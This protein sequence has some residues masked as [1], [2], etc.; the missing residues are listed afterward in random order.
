MKIISRKLLSI[1]L[2]IAM[3]MPTGMLTLTSNAATTLLWPVPGH[4]HN[5]PYQS[6]HQN[7]NGIDIS[8]GS[9]A[10]ANV[11][12]A[13]GGKVVRIY[14]CPNV[15]AP[16]EASYVTC[17]YG[18]GFGLV[19]QG[20]DGRW[21][22][23]AHMLA[24]SIPNNVY[25]GGYVATGTVLGKVGSTGSSTGNHL[26][27][28]IN[29]QGPG[30]NQGPV[31]PM[32]E[33]YVYDLSGLN[34]PYLD[35][36][37]KLDGV[38]KGVLGGI[39]TFD[40]Y[41]NG[42]LVAND[43][44]DYYVAH[45]K[46]T[47]YVVN[48][49]K[50]IGC[51]VLT[52]VPSISGTLNSDTD[53]RFVFETRHTLNDGVITT[54]PTCIEKGVKI[55]SCKNCDYSST[56]DA[57]P[58]GHDYV[59]TRIEPTC[60][61][62]AKY[63]H[64]CSR[65]NESYVKPVT[66]EDVWSDWS[67][68]KPDA[69]VSQ[70]ET[71]TQYRYMGKETKVTNEAEL[72]G[73]TLVDKYWSGEKNSTLEYV[74]SFPA[75][76]AD[77]N[78]LYQQ[79]KKTPPVS[80]ENDKEKVVVGNATTAGYIYWHW[81]SSYYN[82]NSPINRLIN[83]Y[84]TGWDVGSSRPYDVFHA[85]YSTEYKNIT[86]S[87]GAVD[88]YNA[89]ACNQTYWWNPAVPVM[90]VP[91]TT[92]EMMY[93]YTRETQWGEWTDEAP[94]GTDDKYEAREVYRYADSTDLAGHKWDE[95][96]A[97]NDITTY[98]C[99]V[100]GETTTGDVAPPVINKP[101]DNNKPGDNNQPDMSDDFVI[102]CPENIEIGDKISITVFCGDMKGTESG[103]LMFRYNSDFFKFESVRECNDANFYMSSSN[104]D[105]NGVVEWSFV[106]NDAT[107]IESANIV[108]LT[109]TA[110]K[111]GETILDIV[112]ESWN[113]KKPPADVSFNLNIEEK[114]ITEPDNTYIL[115]DVNG[116]GKV[117]AADA[118]IVLR[119][120][121]QLEKIEGDYLLAADINKDGKINASDARKILRVSAQLET[122]E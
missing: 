80:Y 57:E 89:N 33:N 25:Y 26:H 19:I 38:D 81:C 36:N 88:F 91:V 63:V 45:P 10:G 61:E 121:A 98:T 122:L 92:Y 24:D 31:N 73:W 56:A 29:T 64:I 93:E 95:G 116:D 49:I 51:H 120:S 50:T 8:D 17:C 105:K 34:K 85:F 15:H 108:V 99:F 83:D 103:D 65:C 76:F 16:E 119:V 96:K 82:G 75:G 115:G 28:Q 13:I 86:P 74:A 68:E 52:G 5:Q 32:H 107:I 109:F 112:V 54:Q 79:Y 104:G 7:H 55:V 30:S 12:A 35:V 4:S 101:D 21:Y 94:S 48:D 66:E 118:R 44:T 60:T 110:L 47:T 1:L 71:K 97:V 87:S 77:Y 113:G 102:I 114:T 58:L 78:A 39:A 40:V 22:Q 27:F 84:Y 62:N 18:F 106:Y 46:G 23:Y 69:S 11:V 41:I 3:L 42:S 72:V 37:A 111:K 2:V 100:C 117:N 90:S 53:C 70:T 43:Q 67:T 9:I 59:A 20:D 6:F 14:K